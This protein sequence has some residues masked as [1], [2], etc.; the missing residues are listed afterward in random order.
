MTFKALLVGIVAGAAGMYV[1]YPKIQ[2][3]TSKVPG[4]ESLVRSARDQIG[5]QTQPVQPQV[6]QSSPFQPVFDIF[7]P[8]PQPQTYTQSQPYQQSNRSFEE[9]Q[10]ESTREYLRQRRT[11]P[12]PH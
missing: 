10:A 12:L 7:K 2:Q 11:N 5:F 3:Y 8:N 1:A 6:Q 4:V 9:M